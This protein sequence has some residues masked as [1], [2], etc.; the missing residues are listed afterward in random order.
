MRV[1]AIVP[2]F[3]GEKFI[4]DCLESLLGQSEK[5]AEIIVVDDGSSDSTA[6]ICRGFGVKVLQPGHVGRSR[7]RN[8]GLKAAKHEIVFFVEA[9][10]VYSKNFLA[11]CV[12]RF[13]GKS[14]GGVIGKLEVRNRNDGAWTGCRAAE[15]DSRFSDYMPFTA[16]M[17]R[18]SVVERLGG[19]DERL[20][21]G[22]DVLLGEGVRNAGYKIVYEP[23]A[24][25]RH[26]EP[27]SLRVVLRKSW[28]RGLGL[29]QKHVLLWRFPKILLADALF[30]AF[31][32]LGIVN[33]F[34]A[35]AAFAF[36][37]AQVFV[38][39]KQFFFI[40]RG[41]WPHLVV[42]LALNIAVFKAARL[43]GTAFYLVKG[44]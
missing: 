9:D 15:L 1:S 8:L 5:F 34:F 31:V 7:A 24:V 29:G 22:E 40:E 19:F 30:F 23:K 2:V 17:Y 3:N 37:C 20:D 35:L 13:S 36:L 21:V 18:K 12:R 14:V 27:S 39:R 4:A 26:L 11:A 33:V 25:W 38:R 43:L 41:L 32:F 42:F 44:A 10:A 28:E 16:W 6:K